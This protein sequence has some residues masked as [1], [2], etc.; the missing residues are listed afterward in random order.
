MLPLAST[1]RTTATLRLWLSCTLLLL[2]TSGCAG[3]PYVHSD[4]PLAEL[5]ARAETQSSGQVQVMASVASPEETETIFGLPLYNQ[6]IQPIWLEVT[7][8]SDALARYAPVSTDR[9][10]FPPYEVAYKN[11]HGYDKETRAVMEKRM[12]ALSM[13]R[14]IKPGETRS[15]FVF[16]H[17]KKGAKDFNVD[18]FSLG[19]SYHFTYL[20]RVPGFVPD[21]ANVDFDSIYD[22]DEVISVD[23]EELYQAIKDLPCCS[24]D[25]SNEPTDGVINFALV[26]E[27]GSLLRGLLRSHWEEV[28]A[29]EAAQESPRFMFGRKQDATLRYQSSVDDGYYEMRVWLAPFKYGD[30][31]VWIGQTQHFYSL[32]GKLVVFDPDIDNARDFLIQNVMYGQALEKFAWV[33]GSEVVPAETF[34]RNLTRPEFFTDGHRVALWLTAEPYSMVEIDT[35]DWDNPP[36]FGK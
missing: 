14:Y 15:G 19:R 2:L 18:L 31:F 9:Y 12:S 6:G 11:R 8:D 25:A 22:P 26:G 4:D 13:P 28:S 35:L 7:N 30:E 34:F 21:Y 17:L 29:T 3:L 32:I 27:G 16:T 36:R 24:V 33:S 5:R 23:D 20:L 1:T 10:Y